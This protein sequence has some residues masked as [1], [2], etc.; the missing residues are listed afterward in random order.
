MSKPP[1]IAALIAD[2]FQE[3]EC[4]VPRFA[5]QLLGA[6]VDMVSLARAPV[7]IYSYFEKVGTYDVDHSIDE[8]DPSDFDGI[9][10][11]GGAKSPVILSADERVKAFLTVTGDR[12]REEART[13]DQRLAAGEDL[14]A[15]AGIP[16]AAL[17][18]N[19]TFEETVFVLWNKRLPKRDELDRFVVDIRAQYAIPAQMRHLIEGMPARAEPMHALRTA[20]SALSLFDP[21]PDD[22]APD[23]VRI[24]GIAMMAK[25]P[26]LLT[27]FHRHRR[28]QPI[29]EPDPSLGLAANTLYM[30]NGQKPSE[31]MARALD[32]CLI[33][34]ADHGF[35]AS[36]FTARV[37]TST[38]SDIASAVAGAIG[39]MKGPLHGGAPSEVVDQ[40]AHVG[41]AEHA[42]EWVRDA[43]DRGER[44]MGFGHRVYRAEDPRA[45][46]L[47]RTAK[48]LGAPR[49]EV[50]AAL[51]EAALTELQARRP[52]RVL[53][54]NVEF[55]AAIMLDFAEVPAHMFTSMFTCARTAGWSAHIL[56][57]KQTGRL[58]RPS[59][60]YIGPAPRSPQDVAGW[61][62][63]TQIIAPV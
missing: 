48:E 60:Q 17:A 28:G 50:A 59:A 21:K 34:H 27:A 52:D 33:L 42:E 6:R 26:T 20:V 12:G 3:E 45:R 40:L 61:D 44:L 62:T 11:P 9:L 39:T 18:E 22:I 15:V 7:E 37:I 13:V 55:W 43:L 8:V 30:L 41:S 1:R 10:I 4:L 38:R 54:T 2:G 56:E 24:K 57:Q 32:V 53:A 25:M 29:V 58:V 16:I 31:T 36:T 47:R 49:Y 35:N 14:P 51:E 5:L 19:S 63:V 23:A 46:V